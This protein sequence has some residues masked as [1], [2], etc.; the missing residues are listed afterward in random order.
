MRTPFYIA[1]HDSKPRGPIGL[2]AALA[3]ARRTRTDNLTALH[4]LRLCPSDHFLDIGTGY[5][6]APRMAARQISAGNVVGID[7]ASTALGLARLLAFF[8]KGKS[9]CFLRAN[10]SN[11]P[12]APA[13]FTC[14]MAM[15]TL[16]FWSCPI[17]HFREA[18]RI[19][20][21]GGR[22]L[23]G[24]HPPPPTGDTHPFPTTVYQLRSETE[25]RTALSFA[26][27][28]DITTMVREATKAPPT[29]FLLARVPG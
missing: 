10:S 4:M 15:H 6:L 9:S 16:Y 8:S 1:Q 19:L 24:F 2:L 21:P 29:I 20:V 18:H 17:I 26:G 5:G 13:T 11:L 25:V 12:F 27:F 22:F 23:V 3:G 14:A 7:H 28:R